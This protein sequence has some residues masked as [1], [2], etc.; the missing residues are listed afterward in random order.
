[1]M[2]KLETHAAVAFD[3][4]MMAQADTSKHTCEIA[5]ALRP[6][7]VPSRF[8][9]TIRTTTGLRTAVRCFGAE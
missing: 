3:V 2:L 7:F 4:L 1:M 8:P 9:M 6:A 5:T